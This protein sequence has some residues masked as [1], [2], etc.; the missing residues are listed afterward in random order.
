MKKLYLKW[1]K[2]KHE[3]SKSSYDHNVLAIFDARACLK[4]GNFIFQRKGFLFLI[5]ASKKIGKSKTNWFSSV[6]HRA[7]MKT[8][9][10]IEFSQ[11]KL[12]RVKKVG[13]K[14]VLNSNFRLK[15]GKI[16]H[17]NT[18]PHFVP[19]K[20]CFMSHRLR[21][22]DFCVVYLLIECLQKNKNWIPCG[23]FAFEK[24]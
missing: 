10:M 8:Q 3:F 18:V 7:T 1:T 5:F 4:K 15:I 17:D 2:H 9:K 23:R 19:L 14:S 22:T 11:E 6:I 20:W 24:S 21:A 16:K 13:G 12:E